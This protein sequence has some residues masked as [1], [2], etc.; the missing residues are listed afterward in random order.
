M[1]WTAEDAKQWVKDATDEQAEVG[2]EVANDALARCEAEKGEDCEASA[3]RQAKAIMSKLAESGPFGE[4]LASA[5]LKATEGGNVPATFAEVKLGDGETVQGWLER[6]TAAAVKAIVPEPK[7]GVWAYVSD[8]FEK[9]LVVTV[10]ENGSAAKYVQMGYSVGADGIKFGKPASVERTT[11]YKPAG[12]AA[13]AAEAVS[14]L[15]DGKRAT[16]VE[17]CA[18][19]PLEVRA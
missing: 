13:L 12:V 2:A 3:I 5:L 6:L 17:T 19:V 9:S 8:V 18:A 4:R 10:S 16:F 7:E 14:V 1:P 15:R 11:V